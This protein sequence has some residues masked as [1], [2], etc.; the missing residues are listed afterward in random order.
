MQKHDRPRAGHNITEERVIKAP[1]MSGGSSPIINT[2][3]N[4]GDIMQY[5]KRAVDPIDIILETC[6][7]RY[8]HS[9]PKETFLDWGQ[10][11]FQ[12][13]GRLMHPM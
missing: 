1:V 4:I 11:R 9:T 13:L 7:F 12:T 3:A 6:N 8:L 2:W 5:F 10:I